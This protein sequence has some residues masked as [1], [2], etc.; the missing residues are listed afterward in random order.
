MTILYFGTYEETYSRNQIII[1]CL[2]KAG[3]VVKECH[4]SLWKNKTDKTGILTSLYD[5]LFFLL[6]LLTIYMKL[7]M[8]YLHVG[9]YDVVFIGYPGHLDTL[10]SKFLEFISR[11]K[12][13]IVFD[14]FISLYDTIVSDRGMVQKDSVPGKFMSL[15]DRF[16][17][18]SADIILLDTQAHI[19]YFKEKYRI[20]E[21]KLLKVYA[22]ADTSIFKTGNGQRRRGIFQALFIGKYTPL[23]GIEHIVD[24]AE[25]LTDQ[26]DVEFVFIGKGQLYKNI[27]AMADKKYL[28]NIRFIEWVAYESLPEYIEDADICLGIFSK[29]AKADRVIPNKIFQAMAMGKPVIS[30]RTRGV[31][32]LLTHE[33]NIFLCEPGSPVALADAILKLKSDEALRKSIGAKARQTFE[34]D[35]GENATIGALEKALDA[36]CHPRAAS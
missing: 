33:Q 11:R 5:V 24:A 8:K 3:Y 31:L 2:K 19:N 6:R 29:S 12:R 26:K 23:H 16:S 27:R 36:V 13:K 21:K 34:E 4:V 15:L 28:K 25:L 30:G 14:A 22:S 32:E 20:P 18:S 10:I 17:C 7:I 1:K 35:A 9:R